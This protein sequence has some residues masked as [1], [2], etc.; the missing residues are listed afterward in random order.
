MRHDPSGAIDAYKRALRVNPSY[1]PAALAL[2]DTQW[3]EGDHV[4]AARSYKNIVDHFPDG[5]YPAYVNQRAAG[6]P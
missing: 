6:G 4:S 5:T 1:V 3:A 2:A